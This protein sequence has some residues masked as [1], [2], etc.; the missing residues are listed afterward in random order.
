MIKASRSSRSTT[1]RVARSPLPHRTTQFTEA[2]HRIA[3]DRDNKVVIL[4]GAGDYIASI[5]FSTF[6]NV[7]DHDVWSRVH[8]EGVQVLENI[9]NI[10]VPMIAAIK[11]RAHIHS[12]AVFTGNSLRPCSPCRS[13]HPPVSGRFCG[14]RDLSGTIHTQ[15]ARS[16][17]Q[18]AMFPAPIRCCTLLPGH[19]QRKARA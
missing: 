8:D 16:L 19:T 10:R 11:G 9:A 6:G 7:G 17:C 3:R 13:D 4:T 12:E 15:T 14:F 2:F 1:A 5:D 18:S